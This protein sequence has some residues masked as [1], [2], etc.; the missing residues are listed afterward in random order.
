MNIS[1]KTTIFPEVKEKNGEK[2]VVC[3]TTISSKLENGEYLN[4]SV[5][6]RF[7]GNCV[8]KETLLKLDPKKCYSLQI[9]EGFL[10]CD[11]YTN[12]SGKEVRFVVIVV[13]KG[14]LK[15]SKE[16]NR[17]VEEPKNEDLPF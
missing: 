13:T 9:D 11:A 14:T 16:V 12:S 1:G 15:G 17:P 5:E 7:S 6:V 8:K 3:S 2:F 4:K 10:S